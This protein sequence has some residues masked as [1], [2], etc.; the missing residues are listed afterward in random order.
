MAIFATAALLHSFRAHLPVSPCPT[1]PEFRAA[2]SSLRLNFHRAIAKKLG[3]DVLNLE[4]AIGGLYRRTELGVSQEKA[5]PFGAARAAMRCE[6]L[7][8]ILWHTK[9]LQSCATRLV[10][11]VSSWVCSGT[12]CSLMVTG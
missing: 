5:V 1:R 12:H 2:F 8:K 11:R 9:T 4:W 6:G 3:W 10:L 7:L